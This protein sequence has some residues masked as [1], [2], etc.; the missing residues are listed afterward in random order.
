MRLTTVVTTFAASVTAHPQGGS[1][2]GILPL[3]IGALLKS[4]GPAPASDPRFTTFTPP[5]SGDVRSPCPGLNALANHNFI[6]HNG[7]GN[8]IPVLLKGLAQGLNMGPDFTVAVGG[9]GLLASP[10]PLGGSFDLDDLNQ[11][12][13][14]IEHDASMSRQ[15]AALGNDQPFY[16]PNWDQYISFF[17]GKAT[18]DVPTASQAKFARY[19]DSLTRNPDFTYG[20]REAVFSYGENAIYLQ[21][22][23]DPITGAAKIE[24]VRQLFEKE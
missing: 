18:T 7:R 19:N 23:S 13:F 6:P 1:L 10:N 17:D 16:A 4:L 11:H 24:Y 20:L 3:D 21:A 9:A 15:D 14:P 12:N 8:T 22:M 2:L 5:G